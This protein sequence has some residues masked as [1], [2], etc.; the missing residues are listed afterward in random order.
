[1]SKIFR[2]YREF[3]SGFDF[4]YLNEPRKFNDVLLYQ[5][6]KTTCDHIDSHLH[7]DFFEL[8]LI[9]SGKGVFYIDNKGIE[10]KTGDLFLAMPHEVHSIISKA[11]DPLHYFHIAFSFSYNS[12]F[13]NIAYSEKFIEMDTTLRKISDPRFENNFKQLIDILKSN[14]EY[15]D[16]EFEYALK[17]F[18]INSYYLYEANNASSLVSTPDSKEQYLFFK[19]I[20]YIEKHLTEISKLTD[21]STALHYNYVYL[22]RVFKNHYGESLSE[23]VST[24][25][26]DY[27]KQLILKREMSVGEIS[28]YLGFS[29]LPVFSK[30]FKR[31]FG[32]SPMQ[33]LSLTS[34]EGM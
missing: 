16:L 29:C 2:G 8:S 34:E 22:A 17:Q 9:T 19:T 23:Y 20:H 6:G 27:A 4:I 31:K 21:V 11:D 10:V 33:Y 32:V 18:A 1:M 26:M 28:D 5:I 14:K 30:S 25:K 24:K 15:S 13:R 12:P 7:R 3:P